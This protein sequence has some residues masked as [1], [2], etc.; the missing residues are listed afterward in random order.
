MSESDI[1]GYQLY[2]DSVFDCLDEH[3]PEWLKKAGSYAAWRYDHNAM[4]AL[5]DRY[6]IGVDLPRDSRKALYWLNRL[7]HE[8]RNLVQS[9]EVLT[10][11]QQILTG[12]IYACATNDGRYDI[13]KVILKDKHGVQQLI[14]PGKL[15]QLPTERNPIPLLDQVSAERTRQALP[16]SHTAVAAK[17]F[18]DQHAVF[19][20]LL[21]VNVEELHC[22]RTHLKEMFTGADFQASAWETLLQKAEDGEIQ[23]Q[24]NI[25]HLYLEGDQLWEVDKNIHEAVRWFTKAANQGDGLAAYTL[26]IIYQQGKKNKPNLKLGF[27]WLLYAAQLN[28]G[29]AQQHTADCYRQ[30]SGCA[31]DLPLA[32]A[33]YSIA[34]SGENELTEQQKN[35]AEINQKELETTL[36]AKQLAK[37]QEYLLQL[38]ENS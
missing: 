2:V 32:H 4:T 24:T 37:A 25:A 19:I 7:V 3:T 31:T 14:F 38:R 13:R 23:A 11:E 18:L 27:E 1:Q 16:F 28:Y 26:A 22:Y 9:G 8:G 33:W 21:P 36:S 29:L 12:G 17:T 5:A 20:G 10:E 30:G 15:K 6:L 34:A 35:R